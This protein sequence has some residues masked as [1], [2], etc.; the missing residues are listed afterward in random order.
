MNSREIDAEPRHALA[1]AGAAKLGR[2]SLLMIT[3]LVLG[4]QAALARDVYCGNQNL[5]ATN[6]T[7]P[8]NL[9]VKGRCVVPLG[10]TYYFKDVNILKDGTLWFHEGGSVSTTEFWASA[11]IIENGGTMAANAGG[12][13]NDPPRFGER[14]SVLTIYLYGKNEADWDWDGQQFRQ[15]NK[16]T[17]CKSPLGTPPPD[18]KMRPSPCGIP[19]ATWNNN[20]KDIIP[21]LPG[22][23]RDFF[24]QYGP[25]HGDGKC[26][27]GSVFKVIDGRGT[28]R[29]S[30][31]QVGYF[32]NK[33]LAVSYGG[34]LSLRGFKGV[35]DY[36]INAPEPVP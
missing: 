6:P 31:G 28:C 25:L 26:D 16:G 33:V 9:I 19:V 27:D 23:V 18:T 10:K 21:D 34:T 29:T 3:M 11:I 12:A 7:D 14:G 13:P 1:R 35:G 17:L 4:A 5:P 15:Q 2:S 30:T 8:P 20:G 32:G 22:G 24:Y 36:Y